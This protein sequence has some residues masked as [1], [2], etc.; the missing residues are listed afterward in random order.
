MLGWQDHQIFGII[1]FMILIIGIYIYHTE[2]DIR[3]FKIRTSDFPV[4]AF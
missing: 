4:S 1:G 2:R 3:V